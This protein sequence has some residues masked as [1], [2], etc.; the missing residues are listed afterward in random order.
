MRRLGRQPC[1][2]AARVKMTNRVT[3]L[4][5]ILLS[6]TYNMFIFK[7]MINFDPRKSPEASS[8]IFDL[9]MTFFF[10]KWKIPME[11][12]RYEKLRKIWD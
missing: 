4:N 6:F 11:E 10:F 9:A 2:Q 7:T 8:S 1:R 5:P 3:S 12:P